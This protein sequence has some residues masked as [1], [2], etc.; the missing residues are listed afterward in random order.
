MSTNLR[1]S[2]MR[3]LCFVARAERPVV[4]SGLK[5][6]IMSMCVLKQAM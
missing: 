1:S 5:S 6:E 2:K 4:V 3:K